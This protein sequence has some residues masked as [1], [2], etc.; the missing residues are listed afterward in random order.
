MYKVSL[1]K[2]PFTLIYILR[3]VHTFDLSHF[4]ALILRKM[5][6]ALCYQRDSHK[7][8]LRKKLC[9]EKKSAV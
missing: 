6:V 7:I 1:D 9:M 8:T 2:V 3:P 4:L 5:D